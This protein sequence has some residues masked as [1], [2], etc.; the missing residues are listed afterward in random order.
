MLLHGTVSEQGFC[1]I[2]CRQRQRDSL[3][4]MTQLLLKG[5]SFNRKIGKE[6]FE[7]LRLSRGHVIL[8]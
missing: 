3:K 1:Q 2:A 7:S 8:V 6:N 5:F 4:G